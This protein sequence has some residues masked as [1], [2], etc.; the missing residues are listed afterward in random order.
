MKQQ[1]N[2]GRS[3]KQFQV[4]DFVYVKLQ[5]YR[6]KIIANRAC[7]KLSAKYF[8][9]YKVDAKV[10]TVAYKLELSAEARFTLHS[11]FLNSKSMLVMLPRN[12]NYLYSTQ[13][14]LLPRS[15]LLY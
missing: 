6:Q 1:E 4:G 3:D 11:M 15:L 13:M 2:K 7:L 10:G 8:G 5:P 12:P 14:A 9:P